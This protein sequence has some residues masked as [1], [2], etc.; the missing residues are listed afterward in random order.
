MA[1]TV[2]TAASPIRAALVAAG[3][4]KESRQQ[5]PNRETR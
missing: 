2:T 1:L 3:S 5:Q 4:P